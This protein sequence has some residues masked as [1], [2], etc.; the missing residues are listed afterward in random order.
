MDILASKTNWGVYESSKIIYV[1]LEPYRDFL[2]KICYTLDVWMT[3]FLVVDRSE[4]LDV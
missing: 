1:Y 4:K 3:S 2:F